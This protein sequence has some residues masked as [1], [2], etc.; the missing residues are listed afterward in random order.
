MEVLG[1]RKRTP[2]GHDAELLHDST[3]DCRSQRSPRFRSRRAA[4]LAAPRSAQGC[5]GAKMGTSMPDD[6]EAR[7]CCLTLCQSLD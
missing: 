7:P 5:P 6:G 3:A 1:C 2:R 4:N